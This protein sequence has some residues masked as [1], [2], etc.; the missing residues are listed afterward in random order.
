MKKL[1]AVLLA[2]ALLCAALPLPGRAA[3][4]K[5]VYLL[6]PD[7]AEQGRGGQI[8]LEVALQAQGGYQCAA[9]RIYLLYDRDCFTWLPGETQRLGP[10]DTGQFGQRGAAGETN[11]YPD[12]MSAQER[13]A[14]SVVVLQWAYMPQGDAAEGADGLIPLDAASTPLPLLSLGFGVKADAPLGVSRDSFRIAADTAY[15]PADTPYFGGI[16]A[17]GA[18]ARVQ[19]NPTLTAAPGITIDEAEGLIYGFPASLSRQGSAQ[20]WQNADLSAWL[21]TDGALEIDNTGKPE[22]SGVTGTGSKIVLRWP[23]GGGVIRSYAL[24]VFGDVDGNGVVDLND[25]AELRAMLAGKRPDKMA[26]GSPYRLAA[27]VA[28]PYDGAPD[29]DDLEALYQAA[30]GRGTLRA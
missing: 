12:G 24:V 18:Q 22:N 23:G 21:T 15:G 1:S 2:M 6:R 5:L 10:V 25:Y 16:P 11:K 17:E 14:Y 3:G 8:G 7:V 26:A 9:F 29:A 27:D 28:P 4:E 19:I 30:I 13:E 20:N